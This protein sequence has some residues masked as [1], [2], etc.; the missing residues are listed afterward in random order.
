MGL[1]MDHSSTGARRREPHILDHLSGQACQSC[2]ARRYYLVFRISGGGREA[3]LSARCS[4]CHHKRAAFS[5]QQLA[6]DIAHTPVHRYAVP[7]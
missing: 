1:S 2:G 4:H 6:R 3:A 5:E 7:G